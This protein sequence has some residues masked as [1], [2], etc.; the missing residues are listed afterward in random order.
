MNT[1][2][3]AS[4]GRAPVELVAKTDAEGQTRT[5]V[6]GAKPT[7]SLAAGS[8]CR[9][10]TD[11]QR[12]DSI[13]DQTRECRTEITRRGWRDERV[14]SD[15]EVSRTVTRGRPGYQDLLRAAAAGEI[16]VIVVTELSRLGDMEEI[17]HLRKR[18]AVWGVGL[19]AIHDGLDTITAPEA[20]STI[21][22]VK[23]FVSETEL[24]A[25]A[26]RTRRGIEGK[27]REG[28]SPGGAPFGY[29]SRPIY[30]DRPG[31]PP[32]SGPTVGYEPY[33]WEP[34]AEVVRRIF[35][36]YRDG[37]S[38]RTIAG[39]LNAEGVPPPGARWANR[40]TQAARTWSASAIWG[41]R[42]RG[43]GILNNERY[44][45]RLLW[46]RSRWLRDPDRE[47]RV[48]R[49]RGQQEWVVTQREDLRIIPDEL[50]DE[51]K[52]CQQERS[53]ANSYSAS[54]RRQRR[55]LS[56]LLR[57]GACGSR[58]VLHGANCYACAGRLNR[59]DAVCTSRVT[60][61]AIWAEQAIL[62]LLQ[63]ALFSEKTVQ[64]MIRRA[65]SRL[66]ASRREPRRAE[67]LHEQLA[68][69]EEEA[70]RLVKAVA[71][72][73]LVDDLTEAMREVEARRTRLQEEL[74]AETT[75]SA[76]A[77]DV[78][79]G[80]VQRAMTD[81]RVMLE[82][83]QTQAVRRAVSRMITNIEVKGAE[84][85]GR[86]RPEPRLYLH[87]NLPGLLTLA[88]GKSTKLVAGACYVA[89]HNALAGVL[90]RQ[91]QLPRQ[92]RRPRPVVEA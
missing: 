86:K 20:A 17:A 79:P 78:I 38:A 31:E 23:G 14:F 35:H 55:L 84:I 8:Y 72:G 69:A 30:A 22:L 74:E 81:L 67:K 3:I 16:D 41:S 7:G 92:G 47:T 70:R 77:L 12:S 15:A 11:K 82:G 51:V 36:F 58:F 27:V 37:K 28:C 76:E 54:H 33:V 13:G 87:G 59:G 91:W 45:G 63:T 50:W 90:V 46:N 29:R 32:E 71:A 49:E 83:G 5:A 34:E 18:L 43:L 10:S 68:Q 42:K 52:R 4:K 66:K 19:V 24:T 64:E 56:G 44:I 25:I 9:Y 80:L 57:C 89:I 21:A 73:A 2:H 75:D 60:V 53:S 6:A 85:P 39:I 88:A 26:H 65:R 61:S 48:R 62:E 1:S 40:T